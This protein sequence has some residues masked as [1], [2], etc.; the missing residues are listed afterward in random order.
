MLRVGSNFL[1]NPFQHKSQA[2]PPKRVFACRHLCHTRDLGLGTLC[3]VAS[4]N[5]HAP[6]HWDCMDW[7]QVT[8]DSGFRTL[9]EP[10]LGEPTH[11]L[12]PCWMPK[13]LPPRNQCTCCFAPSC[14][15]A[16][17]HRNTKYCTYCDQFLF[18]LLNTSYKGPPVVSHTLHVNLTLFVVA[19][20]NVLGIINL[21]YCNYCHLLS[22]FSSK[23]RSFLIVIHYE[24]VKMY[25]LPNLD[26]QLSWDDKKFK[27]FHK[28]Y[29]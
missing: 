7:P 15:P 11:T 2:S 22:G 27:L 21:Q 4:P 10:N 25:I 26:E 29:H 19:C 16:L 1:L 17:N 9:C 8:L 14:E 18:V 13:P 20:K 12:V 3:E 23:V 6:N 24:N 28:K 5:F